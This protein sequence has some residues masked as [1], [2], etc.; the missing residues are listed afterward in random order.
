MRRLIWPLREGQREV[1]FRSYSLKEA[2]MV[3]LRG[4]FKQDEATSP[5]EVYLKLEKSGS[6]YELSVVHE[7]GSH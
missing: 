6:G 3:K 2:G 5:E 7:D 4:V 1:R